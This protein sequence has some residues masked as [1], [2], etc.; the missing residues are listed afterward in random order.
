MIKQFIFTF[1]SLSF[2]GI[3]CAL[4]ALFYVT[5]QPWVSFSALEHYNASKPSI[6]L[7]DQGAEWT[8]FQLDR[9]EAISYN[10]IP[11]QLINAFIAAEDWQFFKHSG[12]SFRGILRSIVVNICS[13]RKAQGASTITQQLVRLLFF[14]AKKSFSRKIK[15]QLLA[16][17]VERQFAKEQILETYLNHVYFGAGIYGVEAACQRF[18][19]INARDITLAQSATLA[20]IVQAPNRYC[21]LTNPEATCK[22]RNNV[23]LKMAKLG[24]ISPQDYTDACNQALTLEKN[25][26]YTRAPHAKES[27]RIFLEDL[28]GKQALYSGGLIIQTTLNLHAQEAAEQ[29]FTHHFKKFKTTINPQLEG[30]L[31]SLD[32]RTGAIKALIGG[33]NFQQSQFN[34][35]IKARRQ[36]GS[37]FKPLI[38][39]AAL[40]K[41]KKFTDIE[42][43]E[44]L[45]IIQNGNEWSPRNSYRSFE[46]PMTLARALSVSGNIIA[47]KLLLYVGI[48][49]IISLAK[50]C[51]LPIDDTAYP[52]LALGCIDS[53]LQETAACIN[54]F[55]NHGIYVKPYYVEWVK[56]QDGK[57]IWQHTKEKKIV[58]SS[59]VSDQVAKV[60]THRLENNRKTNPAL[61][62]SCDILGKTGTTNDARTCSFVGSTPEVTTGVYIGCDDNRALGPR[63]FASQTALPIWREFTKLTCKKNSAFIF[64]PVLREITIDSRTGELVSK[65][66][67]EA[68]ALL[69]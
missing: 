17:A 65:Q 46:G 42:I 20:S 21:P 16:L 34:R 8:R 47:V 39:A 38:Y 4:G 51:G 1:F 40:T 64:N 52:S 11:Q 22:R 67:P 48:P 5:Q 49:T 57:K 12:L 36:M 26:N 19:N 3:S 25:N 29:V 10:Q 35:A 32:R 41:G 69:V 60:L 24:F 15:E 30:A 6:L 59:R 28:L 62:P 37:T 31:I 18:W 23:L 27:I 56:N 33:Y 14:D 2:I 68:L 53:S 50:Q 58:L 45:T 66:K 13:G 54:V 55:A 63:T 9:R 44:A 61:W 7:D 43:D